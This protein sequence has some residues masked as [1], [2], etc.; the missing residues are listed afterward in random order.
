MTFMTPIEYQEALG[1]L[2]MAAQ[3]IANIP[4]DELRS[5]V[6]TSEALGPVLEPTAWIRGGG[7][8]LRDAGD[9]IE[10]AAPLVKFGRELEKLAEERRG[11]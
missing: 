8:N 1:R 10:A 7:Q 6:S 4:I 5:H 9:L 3:V 11:S 2:A